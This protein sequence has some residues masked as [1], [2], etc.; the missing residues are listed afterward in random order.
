MVALT[1]ILSGDNETQVTMVTV[2]GERTKMCLA[3]QLQVLEKDAWILWFPKMRKTEIE[4][5]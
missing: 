5:G 1:V 3:M 2:R 4:A